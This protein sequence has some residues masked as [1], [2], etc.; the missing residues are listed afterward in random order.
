[1]QHDTGGG[2]VAVETNIIPFQPLLG[3]RYLE[4]SALL[5]R[6][7][8]VRF[9]FLLNQS[10][11]HETGHHARS[12]AI[13]T[14]NCTQLHRPSISRSKQSNFPYDMHDFDH[15]LCDDADLYAFV[16]LSFAE[17]GRL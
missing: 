5:I 1:M 11:Q 3:K 9:A 10:V 15:P 6:Q 13:S 7:V 2:G 8:V 12:C 14:G 4:P 17:V 16:H